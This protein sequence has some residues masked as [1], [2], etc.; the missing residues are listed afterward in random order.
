MRSGRIMSGF[1]VLA[2]RLATLAIFHGVQ[3]IDI[4]KWGD[5][6]YHPL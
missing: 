4:G 6:L 5:I 1:R 3:A 2:V